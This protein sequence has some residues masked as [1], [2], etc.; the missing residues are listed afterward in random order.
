M[1]THT[2]GFP[3][4]GV[5]RELKFAVE[6][7]W[8]D[9]LYASELLEKARTIRRT[10]WLMQKEHGIDV[11]SVG[12]FS[13]YDHMLDM[14]CMLGAVP[15]RFGHKP[16][17]N[18]DIDTYFHMARG[19]S[20]SGGV[21]PME[22]TKWFDTN[23]H[24]IVPEFHTGQTF[25]PS[26]KPLS[27]EF[28]E[29]D[30][31]GLDA[32]AVLPG[33]VT[34][35][36][37]GKTRDVGFDKWSLFGNLIDAYCDIISSCAS[38]CSWIQLDE[39][40]LTGDLTSGMK[41]CIDRAYRKLADV[42]GDSRIM[43]ATYFGGIGHNID[44]IMDLPVDCLHIDTIGDHG[45]V[46][47]IASS[48]PAEMLISLGVVNGR[49]V[50]RTDLDEA[51]AVVERCIG[52]LGPDRIMIAPSCSL[53]H[54][55]VDVSS[56]TEIDD[57]LKS[58][59]SFAVQ[60][61]SEVRLIADA[62]DGTIPVDGVLDTARGVC[63]NRRT[64]PRCNN[65]EVRQRIAL[66]DD[67]IYRRKSISEKRRQVQ[68]DELN[69]P[70][71]PTTT[72]GSF[73]QTRELRQARRLY[74]RGEMAE[75]EYM[76][77]IRDY[78]DDCIGKQEEIGLDVL[79][80]GEPERT[81]MVEYFGELL[82]GFC[83]TRNGW[84]QSYGTR[85]VKPP[86][87]YG[88]VSRPVPM[89]VEWTTWAQTLTDLPVKGMLTG[90]VTILCWS[91]VRDDQPESE[92]CRQIALAVRDEVADLE[93]AGIRIIQ[94]DE[95]AF[96]EG[97]PVRTELRA[98]YYEWA[99]QCFRLASSGVE[100]V[101]QIHTHMCYSEFNEII[102]EIAALDADVISIEA[103]RSDMELLRAFSDYEYPNEIGPGIYDIH[104]PR[105]PSVEEMAGLLKK[106]SLKIPPERL[107]VNPD[108]GL[109]T[110][111]WHEVVPALRNMVE[112]ARLACEI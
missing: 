87:I 57:E 7:Y 110:R 68:H 18:V 44:V 9:N 75:Q 106:A 35:M 53:L 91:F 13:L 90:P 112:A 64:S 58:W 55:P 80:H 49:N 10:N 105:I 39:P 20:G 88:D 93:N 11:V 21:A 62:V 74:K 60:K 69:L 3:R 41:T 71:Y 83:I 95:P 97:A 16:G 94:I 15:P 29:A 40:I 25:I 2:L 50:W 101:T 59:L 79:V 51:I 37:L 85:C 46:E 108:C 111:E 89:T 1:L 92:T 98:G 73:P 84:V 102:E 42:S 5:N 4:I 32:K 81:D 99:A 103:S 33:P 36:T 12:D 86:I 43:L 70:P 23:Y 100:D 96:R 31:D 66:I 6:S 63:E 14:T 82:D 27:T 26:G 8:K 67:A 22:M 65:A 28:D 78:I 109:K 17:E 52:L 56:E 77:I 107:W 61:C 104:S 76:T 38:R 19:S 72:I 47:V 24:Y 54:V 30:S 45:Q 48:V 34:F